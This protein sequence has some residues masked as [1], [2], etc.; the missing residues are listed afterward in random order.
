MKDRI[1]DDAMRFDLVEDR[2]GKPAN[3]GTMVIGKNC[4]I[5]QGMSLNGQDRRFKGTKEFQTQPEALLFIP[6]KG[7]G[8]ILP[9]LWEKVRLFTPWIKGSTS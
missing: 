7:I 5:H 3:K 6:G 4:R 9:G 1:H 2:V 8:D